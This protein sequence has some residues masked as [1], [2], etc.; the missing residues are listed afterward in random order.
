MAGLEKR[1]CHQIDQRSLYKPEAQARGIRVPAR[2]ATC[3]SLACAAGLD[4][5]AGLAPVPIYRR[6]VA[7]WEAV[8]GSGRD[9]MR[10]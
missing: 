2:K 1:D 6:M 5:R 7:G 9:C 10:I 8:R 4:G 3:I